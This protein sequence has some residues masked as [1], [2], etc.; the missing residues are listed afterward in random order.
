MRKIALKITTLFSILILVM[1]CGGN[2][3]N[4]LAL[5][6][7]DGVES[8]SSLLEKQFDLNKE[9]K[10]LSISMNGRTS[11]DI[12]QITIFFTENNKKAMWFY[13]ITMAQLF[14][15]KI[16]STG[17][18]Q[19]A[20]MKALKEFNVNAI[21]TYYADAIAIIEKET[22][23]FTNFRLNSYDLNATNNA[24]II[25]HSFTLLAEKINN[26]TSYYGERLEGNIFSFKF[27]TD[28]K[29]ALICTKGLDVFL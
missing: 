5:E 21:P 6:T 4:K 1:S 10:T 8:L 15:P 2:S 24:N 26:T 20:K 18:E 27:S 16:T 23:E 12:D 25:E 13:S 19:P 9:I 11:N 29:Q 3:S 22:D 28:K 14:K 17:N 7:K